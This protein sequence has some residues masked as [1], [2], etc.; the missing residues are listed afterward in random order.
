MQ[1]KRDYC[2]QIDILNVK[3]CS[4][5]KFWT[6]FQIFCRF[7]STLMLIQRVTFFDFEQKQTHVFINTFFLSISMINSLNFI[8]LN[9]NKRL[10]YRCHF[11]MRF[12]FFLFNSFRM[13]HTC[14]VYHFRLSFD[15]TLIIRKNFDFAIVI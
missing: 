11:N 7:R 2:I 9:M 4:F 5:N 14:I 8:N 6:L 12:R 3:F 15:L 10:S 13:T 1:I